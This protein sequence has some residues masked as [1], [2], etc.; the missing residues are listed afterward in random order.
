MCSEIIDVSSCLCSGIWLYKVK[1]MHQ[2]FL[3]YINDANRIFLLKK[4]HLLFQI[5]R[6][7]SFISFLISIISHSGLITEELQICCRF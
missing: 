7:D 6:K 1:D 2:D 5:L 3:D 4:R